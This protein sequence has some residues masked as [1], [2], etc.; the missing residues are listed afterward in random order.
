MENMKVTGWLDEFV[1]HAVFHRFLYFLQLLWNFSL[2]NP[3]FAPIYPVTFL[4]HAVI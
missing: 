2:Q 4:E 3:D 1:T